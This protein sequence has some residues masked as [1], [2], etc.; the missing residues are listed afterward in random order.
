MTRKEKFLEVMKQKGFA[1]VVDLMI[2]VE[3]IILGDR[4]KAIE[5]VQK[6]KNY[7]SMI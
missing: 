2:R 1:N 5:A 4:G 7:Y 3:S 6:N